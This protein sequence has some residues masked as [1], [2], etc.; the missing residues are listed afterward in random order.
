MWLLILLLVCVLLAVAIYYDS[1][2]TR[3]RID[4]VSIERINR[5]LPQTQCGKCGYA[6][7]RPYAEAIVSNH[8]D[9]NRCPPGGEVTIHNL[10]RLT[11]HSI[12]PLAGDLEPAVEAVAVIDEDRCIGCLKCIKACPVDAIVGTAKMMHTVIR[13]QCT[14]CELCI[15]PCPVD[16]I[17]LVSTGGKIESLVATKLQKK[18]QQNRFL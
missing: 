14:A 4:P 18:Q 10:A 11:G 2:N 8:A 12:K 7:C 1:R 17:D 6:G 13:D 15:P 9:I 5:L 16:C 3:H